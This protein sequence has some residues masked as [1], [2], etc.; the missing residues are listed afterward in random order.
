VGVE[1]GQGAKGN[2]KKQKGSKK[3]KNAENYRAVHKG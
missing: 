1:K 2:S 3:K